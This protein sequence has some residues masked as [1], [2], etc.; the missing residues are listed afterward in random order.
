MSGIL[1]SYLPVPE[2]SR[3]CSWAVSALEG[4]EVRC[5][6]L[7]L[8]IDRLFIS[9]LHIISM[10]PLPSTG[11]ETRLSVWRK[12]TGETFSSTVVTFIVCSVFLVRPP[13]ALLSWD[14][15]LYS[16]FSEWN[17]TSMNRMS[18][19]HKSICLH[20]MLASSFCCFSRVEMHVE[21]EMIVIIIV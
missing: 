18:S 12:S 7:L 5:F 10:S 3:L 17:I 16:R 6:S 1:T 9:Q 19:V 21:R 20:T 2:P 4:G 14:T 8:Y 15:V 11:V 13:F